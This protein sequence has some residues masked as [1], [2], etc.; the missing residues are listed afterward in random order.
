VGISLNRAVEEAAARDPVLAHLVELAGPIKYRPRDP[1]GRFG[2]L[3]RAI[4]YQQL[5]E[6]AAHAIYT[7]VRA[8][9]EE[10]TPA[11]L[12]KVS[13]AALRTAGLSGAKLASLR[14]LSTKLRDGTLDLDSSARLGDAELVAALRGVRGVGRWTAELYLMFELRRLDIWPVD[15]LGIRRGYGRAWGLQPP[16][17]AKELDP[18][19]DRF[20]PYR[21]VAARYCWAADAL[22]RSGVD[23][24]LS[25]TVQPVSGGGVF[26]VV[27]GDG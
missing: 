18:L 22:F 1:D 17:T 24:G 5:A 3:V 15:D 4:V 27:G 20:R 12:V 19:G 10:L 21:S 14:D 25:P 8:T 11:T 23:P 2:A 16:P 26:G 9:V 7:R 13:D 6:R